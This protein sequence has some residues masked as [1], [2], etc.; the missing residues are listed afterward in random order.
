MQSE[1][2]SASC[3]APTLRYGLLT[4]TPLRCS[5]R[6]TGGTSLTQKLGSVL[7]LAVISLLT[8]C[9]PYPHQKIRAPVIDGQLFVADKPLAEVNVHLHLALDDPE[10]CGPSA[11][12]ARTD[13]NGRFRFA[14][15]REQHWVAMAGSTI[16]NW[17]L[18]IESPRGW[19]PGWFNSTLMLPDT[20]I[21]LRCDIDDATIASSP[22]NM[23]C[24]VTDAA[25]DPVAP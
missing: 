23:A 8:A 10:Q 22:T 14:E 19:R 21:S 11:L 5:A 24:R 20:G 15:Q 1:K 3:L 25:A 12:T 17:A 6:R 13:A 7:P 4:Q 9:I 16:N 2:A 18:C